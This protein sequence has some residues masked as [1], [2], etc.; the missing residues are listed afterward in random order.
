MQLRP[1]HGG[2]ARRQRVPRLAAA[3]QPVAGRLLE[4]GARSH[5]VGDQGALPRLD[6]RRSEGDLGRRVQPG[7]PR[8]LLHQDQ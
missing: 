7:T 2:P 8:Q 1:G 3:R 6:R 4:G 5:Q